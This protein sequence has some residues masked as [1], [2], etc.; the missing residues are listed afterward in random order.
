M[1]SN[2]QLKASEIIANA[3]K[4][5]L[6][7]YLVNDPLKKDYL[8]FCANLYNFLPEIPSRVYPEFYRNVLLNQSLA[9]LE[10]EYPELIYEAKITGNLKTQYK[11]TIFCTFHF[12]SYRLVNLYL[13][14]QNI[15]FDL[16]IAGKPMEEQ[17]E[18]FYEI[19]RNAKAE[20][21]TN[22][23]FRILNAESKSGII[24]A[25]KTL[26]SGG[27]LLF[28][29]DGNTGIGSNKENSNLT[30]I[31]FLNSN[32]MSRVGIAFFARH[33][34]SQIIPIIASK[35]ELNEHHIKLYDPIIP[36]HGENKSA[37]L[38][39]I[40]QSI[41][42]VFKMHMGNNFDHWECWLYLEKFL[43]QNRS[44]T[45]ELVFADKP[46]YYNK[47]RFDVASFDDMYVLFDR[48]S[49]SF[50]PI[51]KEFYSCFLAEDVDLPA[52]TTK[53]LITRSILVN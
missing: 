10:Q 48:A 40:T 28:Y 25:V 41:F 2:Y 52:E 4:Q 36:T 14:Q 46:L 7:K 27:N 18:R 30:E 11:S 53:K 19:N 43:P 45:R 24:E 31:E 37:E 13:M 17:G 50:I 32:I 51:S 38:T 39:N 29:I 15:N 34:N 16:V 20:Y 23:N 33:T 1:S 42:N 44:I 26:K 5:T 3:R 22:A 49:Y 12:A 8:T 6:S 35:N 21:G 47:R 9:G